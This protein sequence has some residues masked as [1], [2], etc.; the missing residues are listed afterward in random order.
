[1]K[2]E[3]LQNTIIGCLGGILTFFLGGL[4]SLIISVVLFMII[5]YFTGVVKHFS[6]KYKGKKLS[7]KV[8]LWG[9][10]KKFLYL[11]VI[12]LGFTLDKLFGTDIIRN[13]IC[14]FFIANEGIS[15]LENLG[16]MGVPFPDFLKKYLEVLE[17]K[18]NN[19][20]IEGS[21]K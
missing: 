6:P 10:I 7:S 4:D 15:I 5:D 14:Y 13:A 2:L 19:T 21:D 8:G 20:E 3:T 18:V 17:E 12:T 16:E 11:L 9:A 1:M